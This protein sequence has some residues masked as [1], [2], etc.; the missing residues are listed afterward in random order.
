MTRIVHEPPACTAKHTAPMADNP[1]DRKARAPA[2]FEVFRSDSSSRLPGQH[3]ARTPAPAAQPR[4]GPTGQRRISDADGPS[5]AALERQSV[6]IG[7]DSGSGS[8]QGADGCAAPP[9]PTAGTEA[10]PL[11]LRVQTYSLNLAE[12]IARVRAEQ[13]DAL[14]SLQRMSDGQPPEAAIVDSH[15]KENRRPPVTE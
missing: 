5:S 13:Q 1:L 14:D 15:Q 12:R 6:P 8:S 10:E 3:F 4:S 9:P 2:P 11:T 7:S